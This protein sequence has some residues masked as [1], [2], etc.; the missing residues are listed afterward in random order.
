MEYLDIVDKDDNVIWKNT[1]HDSYKNFTTNRIVSIII[2]ILLFLELICII[3]Y[4][5]FTN[6]HSLLCGNTHQ[7][8][9]KKIKGSGDND[10]IL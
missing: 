5:F 9:I 1:R 8:K 7:N 3:F 2:I 10:N 4:W 6:S